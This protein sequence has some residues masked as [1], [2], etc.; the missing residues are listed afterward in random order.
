MKMI[1]IIIIVVV[2]IVVVVVDVLYV[3]YNINNY[4]S[5][6]MI[7]ISFCRALFN[8]FEILAPLGI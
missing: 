2:V 3:I 7:S 8:P 1:I 5:K 4:P 6:L